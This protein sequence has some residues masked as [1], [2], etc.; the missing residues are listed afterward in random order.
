M[1]LDTDRRDSTVL[2]ELKNSRI[3]HF[4]FLL[5]ST[6]VKFRNK[7]TIIFDTIFDFEQN[8]VGRKYTETK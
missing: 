3:D 1:Y 8:D 6:R 2:E 7:N 4:F 5:A